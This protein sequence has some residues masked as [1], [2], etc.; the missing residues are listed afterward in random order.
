MPYAVKQNINEPA[1]YEERCTIAETLIEE[2]RL[3]IP[4]LVDDMDNSVNDVYKGLPTRIFLI[5][6]DGKLGVAGGRGPFGL[7]PAFKEVKEWFKEYRES[8]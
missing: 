5:Q 1:T 8:I 2:K 6:P 7:I 3:T 4:C